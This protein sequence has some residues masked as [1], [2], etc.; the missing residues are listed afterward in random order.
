MPSTSVMSGG[1]V[2]IPKE[3]RQQLGIRHGSRIEFALVGEHVEM[4]VT[5]NNAEIVESGFGRLKSNQKSLP[6]DFDPAK[7]IKR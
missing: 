1:R 2:T 5:S 4:R 3:I 7:L 6:V